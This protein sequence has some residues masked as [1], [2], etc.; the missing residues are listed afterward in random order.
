MKHAHC[1][2]TF[3]LASA[4]IAL[5]FAACRSL[6][7]AGS[8][9]LM[10]YGSMHE[11]IGMQNHQARVAIADVI[12]KQNFYALGAVEGLQGEITILDSR[13]YV[14]AAH[15]GI[16]PQA[17]PA[18]GVQATMLVG[19]FVAAW[20]Q[21]DI[22]QVVV[23]EKVD[24]TIGQAAMAKS[25]DT[26]KPFVFL[27]EGEFSQ[28]RLHVINGACPIRAR[29]KKEGLDDDH[30]PYEFNATRI[31][32]TIVGIYAEDSVGKL[33]HP[34]TQQHAHLI[35]TDPSS[36]ERITGHL[37]SYGIRPGAVLKLPADSKQ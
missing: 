25:F 8:P 22:N 13:A 15:K 27:L 10:Q 26:S 2:A 16:K 19:Q 37:E 28:V 33:T 7:Q 24:E 11:T 30:R 29:M 36:G 14:S 1:I 35:Y 34:A 6:E 3:T 20:E 32:G 5:F 12:A 23:Y 31:K 21:V 4:L 18:S 17:Q 9:G